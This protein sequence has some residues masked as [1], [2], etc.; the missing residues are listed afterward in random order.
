MPPADAADTQSAAESQT[1][2][3]LGI[4]R[5]ERGVVDDREILRGAGQKRSV[6]IAKL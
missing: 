4:I 3:N 6:A 1:A 5:V 2:G